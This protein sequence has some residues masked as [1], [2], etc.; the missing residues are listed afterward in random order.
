MTSKER[1]A[2]VERY[3][4]DSSITYGLTHEELNVLL[5]EVGEM[6]TIIDAIN[7]KNG[8][9]HEERARDIGC[10]ASDFNYE[11]NWTGTSFVR[12]WW[13]EISNAITKLTSG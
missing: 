5:E 4:N 3:W 9:T 12:D 2:L 6:E 7:A 1:K 11:K 8:A 13:T 10:G